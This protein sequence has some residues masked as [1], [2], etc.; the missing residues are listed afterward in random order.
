MINH[1]PT[2][3]MILW[4]VLLTFRS[5]FVAELTGR[6]RCCGSRSRHGLS[7]PAGRS[8]GHDGQLIPNGGQLMWVIFQH[9]QRF[10]LFLW[11]WDDELIHHKIQ[12][13][14]M[15][16]NHWRNQRWGVGSHPKI[17]MLT[18]LNCC[19]KICHATS[20]PK[21]D[22]Q[23]VPS[24]GNSIS[25]VPADFGVTSH[26][27]DTVW[28][29][30][31]IYRGFKQVGRAQFPVLAGDSAWFSQP[32]RRCPART[33]DATIARNCQLQVHGKRRWQGPVGRA[34]WGHPLPQ[35]KEIIAKR[36]DNPSTLRSC[37]FF[38]VTQFFR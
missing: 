3:S 37:G 12:H 35:S 9:T 34:P 24:M 1:P 15:W 25:P 32:F 2:I 18:S 29:I 16:P 36:D 7:D 17:T 27:L 10:L 11:T 26:I 20:I 33:G 8:I 6:S 22:F 14:R 21:A 5:H 13:Q 30:K 31:I 19:P 4:V 28:V 23:E 38:R